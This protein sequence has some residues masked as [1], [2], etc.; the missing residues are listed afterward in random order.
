MSKRKQ[1]APEFKA[2]VSLQAE[3]ELLS[4]LSTWVRLADR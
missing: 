2:K 1:P 4:R 3:A